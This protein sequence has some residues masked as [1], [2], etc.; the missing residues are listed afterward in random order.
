M[1]HGKTIGFLGAGSMAEAL[2]RGLIQGGVVRPEQLIVANRSNR[3][4]L[5]TLHKRYGVRAAASKADLVAEADILVVL[6]KPKDVADLLSEIR[7]YTTRGQVVLSVAAGVSTAFVAAGVAPGVQVVRAMPNTS[8]QVGESAT[9]IALGEGAGDEAR[10]VCR[11][12]LG[13]VGRVVEVPEF[14]L[15]AV[16]GLSG[17]GPAY[18][19]LMI[20]AMVEAG[21][22]VGLPVDVA[23][24]LAVQTLLGAART[25]AETGED[26]ASLRQKVTSPGGTTMAGLQVLHE[27]GFAEALVRAVARATQRSAELGRMASGSQ[28]AAAK[29]A[30]LPRVATS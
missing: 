7:P 15:D 11:A 3:E 1:L 17:S 23:R 26:P 12:I 18:I 4:R 30:S 6:C 14:Q 28:P 5:E 13:A 2:M 24:E 16:T 8:C 10:L 27:A 21:R 19:Y 20:E 29:L 22:G 9:A 25:L